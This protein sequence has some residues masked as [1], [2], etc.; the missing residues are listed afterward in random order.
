MGDRPLPDRGPIVER[1]MSDSR[2]P[3]GERPTVE[4]PPPPVMVDPRSMGEQRPHPERSYEPRFN[5]PHAA[6]LSI[7]IAPTT[8][9]NGPL[10]GPINPV[11]GPSRPK[12]QLPP[13]PPTFTR[14]TVSELVQ[15]PAE[16]AAFA[17]DPKFQQILLRVKEQ[18]L[19]NFISLNRLSDD[20]VESIA[21]DAP[22]KE[23][24]ALARGLIETHL[25]LQ[26]K[27]KA[28]E[29]R[30]LRVQTDLF[31]TQGEIASGQMVEFMVPPELIGL[32]IGKKGARIKQIESETGVTSINVRDNGTFFHDFLSTSPNSS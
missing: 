23:S 18:S 20:F 5:L 4:R 19:V 3:V 29:N 16:L 12:I 28:A 31:S 24:A 1:P 14:P 17:A 10:S 22:S 8:S 2:G 11:I 6:G 13:T 21:I 30:L 15:V 9:S 32:V 27:V 7:P 26:M 25:K